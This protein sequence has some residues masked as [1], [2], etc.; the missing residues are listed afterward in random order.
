MPPVST[1]LFLHSPIGFDSSSWPD[2][3]LITASGIEETPTETLNAASRM[4]LVIHPP[5]SHNHPRCSIQSCH[6]LHPSHGN[7]ALMSLKK[8]I[9][10]ITTM[11]DGGVR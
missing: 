8:R 9:P 7:K 11:T 4:Q 3:T 5:R 1:I 2:V 10:L 6:S